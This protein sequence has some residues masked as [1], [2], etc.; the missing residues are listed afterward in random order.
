MAGRYRPPGEDTVA[1]DPLAGDA[2]EPFGDIEPFDPEFGAAAFGMSREMA[3]NT[4]QAMNQGFQTFFFDSMEGKFHSF[5][6]V[7]TGVLDFTKKIISQIMAQMVTAHEA[8]VV[9]FRQEAQTGQDPDVK[10]FASKT[11]P[12]LEDHLKLAQETSRAVA[13]TGAKSG[14]K[15]GTAGRR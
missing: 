13:T 12:T 11:L 15:V 10:A 14:K 9:A 2:V 7:L 6:D 4:A 3:R 8:A 5:Q 1:I